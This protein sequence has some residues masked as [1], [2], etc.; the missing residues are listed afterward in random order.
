MAARYW[1]GGTD[2]WDNTAGSKWS[3]TS[4]G[5]G[6]ETVPTTAD[7]V[8]FDANSGANTVTIGITAPTRTL[9]MTG[10][11]GTLA[12]GTNKIQIALSGT[13]TVFTGATTYS[14]TGTPLIELTGT[15]GNRTIATGSV[16][17]ANSISFSITAGTTGTIALSNGSRVRNLDF[18][19]FSGVFGNNTRTIYGNAVFST[20]MT[21]TT[22]SLETAWAGTGTQTIT[23]N[24]RTINGTHNFSGV[25]GTRTL[26][27]AF[28]T[29]N[30]LTL[31]AGTFN[32]SNQN[33][34][35]STFSSSNSNTRTLT[36]GSGAWTLSGT[37]TV[38]NLATTTGLTFNKDTANIALSNTSTTA[39][40]FAG[41]GLT[42]NNLSISATT[43]IADY[44]ITGANTFNQIS[45]SK[46]VAYFITL[47][48]ATTTTVTTWAASG[49]SG[50]LLTLRSSTFLGTNTTATLAVTNTFTTDYAA[51]A[52]VALSSS[53]IGTV[54]NGATVFT[55]DIGNWTIGSGSKATNLLTSST[56]WTVPAN[57]NNAD[58]AIHIFG[59][60][61]GGSGPIYVATTSFSGGAGGGG[62]GYRTLTNQ[63]YSGSVTYAIGA[64]GSGVAGGTSGTST[65]GTGGTTTWDSTNTATGGVGGVTTAT[66]ST[67]GTGGTGT[68]SGGTGGDG[69]VT[70]SGTNTGTGG[71]GGAGA[72]G[73]NGAGG[74][75]GDGFNSVT[76]TSIA[77]GGGGGN[78]GGTAG[79][80]GT[81]GVGGN[82]GNNSLG[83]GGAT[84]GSVTTGAT[85]ATNGGGG[86]GISGTSTSSAGS[87]GID[88][89]SVVGG[90]GGGGGGARNLAPSAG[91]LYGGG[92]G[93]GGNNDAGT[94]TN[95]ATGRQGA[96]VIV[97]TPAGG[98]PTA[99]GNFF[100][101]MGM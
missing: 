71:G 84:G 92:G 6:G 58:N 48:A 66:T 100:F 3:L 22:G 43:G 68:S 14:V 90:G 96:I 13:A 8:F 95:G 88:I 97:W 82:G 78:G 10:F 61:G 25:G 2:T 23:S 15:S 80:D 37:G 31:T 98:T 81:S 5:A 7:D 18:T 35:A 29:P 86:G 83:S 24:G 76:N 99:N 44:I 1:V 54:T 40:T 41:G 56:S 70:I 46:T 49:S 4:G 75:G 64:A 39:K 55:S 20:G 69:G 17:E 60:G 26:V 28:S 42:Y 32:A 101:M 19:G 52:Y 94:R 21:F 85:T 93:G 11:T 91:G 33:V 59:G 9:T 38:W 12:F 53:G 87:N 89:L 73:P 67:G 47:P 63:T 65:G 62:G 16:T 30:P 36:M 74:N 27:D 51:V 77:G 45:S 72:A 50:N 34:T 57:W 79:S